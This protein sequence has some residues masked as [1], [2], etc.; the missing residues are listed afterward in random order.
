[1]NT[2]ITRSFRLLVLV[3]L[4]VSNPKSNVA[5]RE[6]LEG[7]YIAH[8]TTDHTPFTSAVFSGL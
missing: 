1:M 3:P 8:Q 6:V 5:T 2:H 4:N 7:V